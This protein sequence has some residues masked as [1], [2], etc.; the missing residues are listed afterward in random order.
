MRVTPLQFR[1]MAR[2]GDA[3]RAFPAESAALSLSSLPGTA[4][5]SAPAF[6][7]GFTMTLPLPPSLNNAFMNVRGKGRVKSRKYMAWIEEARAEAAVQKIRDHIPGWYDIIITLP[8]GMRGDNDNRIKP[9]ND[10]LQRMG[11]VA[12]DRLQFTTVITRAENVKPGTC[13]VVVAPS[14]SS[15]ARQGETADRAPAG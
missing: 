11:F 4:G 2:S 12:D 14:M 1:N 15:V 5:A 6:S 13:F 8:I 10:F 3:R 7:G 9:I